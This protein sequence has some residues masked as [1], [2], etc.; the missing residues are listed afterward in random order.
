MTERRSF[1]TTLTGFAI[2]TSMLVVAI[3]ASVSATDH[4]TPG[5]MAACGDML[6]SATP[7]PMNMD[8]GDHEMMAEIEFDL[9]YIDMMIPHH[10]SIIALAEIAQSTLTDQRLIDISA[11]IIESQTAEMQE[12]QTLRDQ[13]YPDSAIGDPND[14]E[15]MHTAFPSLTTWS[16]PMEEWGNVMSADW[17]VETFC[18]ADNPDLAFVQQVIPHHKMA[19]LVSQDALTMAVHPEI[20]TI[21]ERVI[22]AQ[23]AE[24][25][26]LNAILTELTAATP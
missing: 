16:V 21:A 18:A 7:A 23:Q 14:H 17:Q 2:A 26:V 6:S 9:S 22:P 15:S 3:P 1:R 20:K 5:A 8:M 24:V 4:A 12:L 11:D 13:F 19:I 25:D 10:G